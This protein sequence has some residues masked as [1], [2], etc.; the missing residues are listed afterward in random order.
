MAAALP[1]SALQTASPPSAAGCFRHFVVA[2]LM[3][4]ENPA[5]RTELTVMCKTAWNIA[6]QPRPADRQAAIDLVCAPGGTAG[7]AGLAAAW[8]PVLA[9]LVALKASL[10]DWVRIPIVEARL[11]EGQGSGQEVLT[12]RTPSAT[13]Q[14]TVLLQ[15]STDRIPAV[16]DTLRSISAASTRQLRL[17]DTATGLPGV[18]EDTHATRMSN[19]CRTQLAELVA[20]RRMF[21]YWQASQP[22]ADS[23]R[24]IDSGLDLVTRIEHQTHE[25]LVMLERGALI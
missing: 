23:L 14:F 2:Q 6:L 12:V 18:L 22:A 20:Y 9:D 7:V 8:Q 5:Q 19:D 13:Q 15:P 1:V 17:I 11:D 21:L 16:L 3:C 10:F 4:V 24:Q 25:S